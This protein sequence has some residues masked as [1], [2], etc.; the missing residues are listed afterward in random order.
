MSLA[1]R[2]VRPPGPAVGAGRRQ[3][4]SARLATSCGG[5]PVLAATS[6][7]SSNSGLARPLV[8]FMRTMMPSTVTCSS[9]RAT[10]QRSTAVARIAHRPGDPLDLGA[11]RS[12]SV[13]SV[14]TCRT[15]PGRPFF[16]VT[17]LTQ[18][19][20]APASS[21]AATACPSCS[22]VTSSRFV[23]SSS[24]GCPAPTDGGRR[25]PADDDL[26]AVRQV[27]HLAGAAAEAR[28]RDRHVRERAERRGQRGEQCGAGGRRELD[29]DVAAVGR[30]PLEE[31]DRRRRRIGQPAVRAAHRARS[32]CH[33]GGAHLVDPE[34]LE[35]GGR[36]DDVDDG[37]VPAHLVEVDLVDGSPVQ[38]GLHGGQPVEHRLRP[39]RDPGGQRGVLYQ[40]GDD[41]VGAHHH[42]VSPDDGAGAGDA[43]S[44][45]LLE[46]EVPAG[47][48]QPV[49]EAADLV[50]VGARV[51]ERAQRH[52][53]RDAGEAVEPRHRLRTGDR[54]RHGRSR[55]MAQAAP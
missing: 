25:A 8:T 34:H 39:R 22:P 52:V 28:R 6:A 37:V 50:D 46:L 40:G 13:A 9:A 19:S 14:K 35:G 33:G 23:S 44:D 15:W 43:A 32:R 48:G 55:A 18:A 12:T 36:P 21:A 2:R 3:A 17:G 5:A 27:V 45:A 11:E 31:A 41:A 29:P 53:A 51:D 49:E 20:R 30:D 16:M 7:T 42:V 38:R 1:I 4:S 24:A 26:G 10:G 54:R 47:Q